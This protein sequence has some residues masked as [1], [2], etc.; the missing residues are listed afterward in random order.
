M[1]IFLWKT[2]TVKKN[3]N[4][5]ESTALFFILRDFVFSHTP[6]ALK[7]FD[8][9]SQ[10]VSYCYT[11]GD[12]PGWHS[13]IY[14]KNPSVSLRKMHYFIFI[15]ACQM[16]ILTSAETMLGPFVCMCWPRKDK[17]GRKIPKKK[18]TIFIAFHLLQ[19]ETTFLLLFL[20]CVS[21]SCRWCSSDA[22]I[23]FGRENS[24][25]FQVCFSTILHN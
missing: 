3:K 19:Y 5:L 15:L 10:S 9:V 11:G 6:F 7:S 25:L 20:F 22:S 21:P 14:I 13:I 4:L 16:W 24:R 18:P 8:V 23:C 1:Y 12:F 2:K 17:F